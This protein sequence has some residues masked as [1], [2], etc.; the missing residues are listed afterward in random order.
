MIATAARLRPAVIDVPLRRPSGWGAEAAK[1]GAVFTTTLRSQ[2]AYVGE[3]ALRTTFL[4]IILFV[5][6]QL[7]RATYAAEG[8]ATIA[9][10]TVAQ[11]L[12][13]LA[14]TEAIMTSRPRLS[15]IIDE[16]VR[17]GEIAYRLVR[18]YTYAGYHL[19][20]HAA[21]RA[22]RFLVN[23][24]VG[25]TLALVYVGPVSLAWGGV[26]VGLLAAGQGLLIDFLAL[27]AIGLL[28]F[29]IEDTSSVQLI[30]SRVLMLLGGMLLPLEVFPEPIR[31]VAAALPFSTMVYAP[32][33]LALGG[34]D[35]W[36]VAALLAR[37]VTT[38]AAGA[39]L[40]WLL[41]RAAARRITVNGG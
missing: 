1:Y 33:R 11:M 4:V 25:C 31:S 9:G 18:P 27:F 13:Y 36:W 16:E 41:D 38:L 8:K 35:A 2:L 34:G 20:A 14:I 19:A 7:W 21:E 39:A 15:G 22:L 23:L 5:F 29:W 28:A 12:W 40:V 3:M 10:F 30:Y 24:A 26:A 17:S 6:L 37:Q 32:A